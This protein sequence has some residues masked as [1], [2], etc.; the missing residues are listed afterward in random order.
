[1]KLSYMDINIEGEENKFHSMA[2][3][4]FGKVSDVDNFHVLV[5]K[6]DVVE[7]GDNFCHGD[8]DL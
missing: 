3:E 1:M 2:I 4:I 8:V 6:L 7:Y 5:A